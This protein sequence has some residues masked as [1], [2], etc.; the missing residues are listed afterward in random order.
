MHGSCRSLEVSTAMVR[1]RFLP[2]VVRS[3]FFADS[4]YYYFPFLSVRFLKMLERRT[5][6]SLRFRCMLILFQYWL[7]MD[8]S[9]Q[10][11]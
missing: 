8:C 11:K 4:L 3:I 6:T 7:A 9:N 1:Y 10:Y 2:S 5:G